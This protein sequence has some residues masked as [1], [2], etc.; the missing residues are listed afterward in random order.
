MGFIPED[1]ANSLL[2]GSAFKLP[3]DSGTS[4]R[5]AT[6]QPLA[7]SSGNSRL[8][9]LYD[10]YGKQYN[11]D[12]NLLVA[13]GGQESGFK[14][15]A[16]S[17]KGAKG[18]AQFEPG[19][20]AEYG[21]NVNDPESS[22]RGQAH[23]MSDLLNRTNDVSLS[24]AGYNSGHH[25]GVDRLRRNL[26]NI[27]ETRDYNKRIQSRYGN[28]AFDPNSF[29][30]NLLAST[31]ESTEKE[32]EF[33][34]ND[35]A[36][37]VLDQTSTPHD[38]A[39]RPMLQPPADNQG[40]QPVS[41]TVATPQT[42]NVPPA[43]PTTV[44]SA[45][46]VNPADV[47][48][49]T[50]IGNAAAQGQ[51]Y[52][53]AVPPTTPV[54]S[55]A[56]V[57]GHQGAVTPTQTTGNGVVQ[58]QQSTTDQD[59][60]QYVAYQ[61]SQNAPVADRAAFDAS[62]AQEKGAST[63]VTGATVT[64]PV[65]QTS[66]GQT[67]VAEIQPTQFKAAGASITQEDRDHIQQYKADHPNASADD[68]LNFT[69]GLQAKNNAHPLSDD[70]LVKTDLAFNVD[71]PK[72]AGEEYATT[73]V[74]N[75]LIKQ[76]GMTPEQ[77]AV[78]AGSVEGI[79][80][81]GN[82][83]LTLHVSR[84]NIAAAVGMDKVRADYDKE[85]GQKTLESS[86]QAAASP[87]DNLATNNPVHDSTG[88][89]LLDQAKED[90]SND[91]TSKGT[92]AD[93]AT[94]YAELVRGQ[95]NEAEKRNAAGMGASLQDDGIGTA[96]G[97]LLGS[98]ARGLDFLKGVAKVA[99]YL[100]PGLGGV[101]RDNVIDGS[102][103]DK[104]SAISQLGKII[105]DKSQVKDANGNP[106]LRSRVVSM[107]GGA[108]GDFSR[109]GLQMELPGGALIAFPL[110]TMMQSVG[111]GDIT[112]KTFEETLKS[113]A[114]N[115]MFYGMGELGVMAKGGTL[116]AILPKATV[117]ALADGTAS[118][119]TRSNALLQLYGRG[120]TLGG[121]TAGQFGLSKLEGKSN[122]EALNDA[123]SIAALDFF[124]NLKGDIGKLQGKV[125]EVQN[126]ADSKY[127]T[128]TP[129]DEVVE[130]A[131][132]PDKTDI[133]YNVPKPSEPLDAAFASKP[134][135]EQKAADTTSNEQTSGNQAEQ[136]QTETPSIQAPQSDAVKDIEG[137]RQAELQQAQKDA[138][139]LPLIDT[140]TK[141]GQMRLKTPI[142]AEDSEGGVVEGGS[143]VG[144]AQR[145]ITK[146]QKV[147]S[148]LLECLH[149]S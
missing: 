96:F 122:T 54:Q 147:L 72:G 71:L 131:K 91:F 66:D 108:P 64:P 11:V 99:S 114:Q 123:I 4:D 75:A 146:R 1:V 42:L 21:V 33:D 22:V 139:Q 143:T 128:V 58:P 19:T 107:A 137:Q 111:R 45:P 17:N 83:L 12:P 94:R 88:D 109:L 30:H 140:A 57:Q 138:I 55:P 51:R 52:A 95:A 117:E 27:P 3:V 101:F 59:Y 78:A 63:S 7:D 56:A 102:F 77:A 9:N 23:L 29:A 65:A 68:V 105:E 49:L 35:V 14:S 97:G 37:G 26:Q 8:D 34:A 25:Y 46:P 145:E 36:Q 103:G 74:R 119:S 76:Y 127:Y 73:A 61:Q 113:G 41:P 132:A 118:L 38:P 31:P 142:N 80:P 129:K 134:T 104:M 48:Q 85:V 89:P 120:V 10:K 13:Q 133:L 40:G 84:A 144:A 82:R 124:S 141:V 43:V 136:P 148:T 130:L 39:G 50:D 135:A 121:V 28:F 87:S 32:P 115:L 20:A 149:G 93:I 67:P 100:T 112:P 18:I 24:L 60:Q 81:E 53:P 15:G 90:V 116:K 2:D 126:G 106:T 62:V 44:P 98:G 6:Y 5:P 70:E 16:V 110:D 125:V 86:Q 47:Q 79:T 92:D 69:K